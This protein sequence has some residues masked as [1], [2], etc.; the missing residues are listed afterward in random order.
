[1]LKG[2]I[3]ALTSNG[4]IR[5]WA[6][7]TEAPSTPLRVM[8][9]GS[10]GEVIAEGL[11]HHY[12]DD[13]VAAGCGIGWCEFRLRVETISRLRR[14]KLILVEALTKTPI[15][16]TLSIEYV[17]TPSNAITGIEALLLDDP[18]MARSIDQLK[19]CDSLFRDFILQRGVEA[20]VRATYV[21]VLGRPADF[22]GLRHYTRLIR[23]GDLKPF[24]LLAA[25][26][27]S[28]EF[29]SRPRLLGAPNSATFP[30]SCA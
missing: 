27:D 22:S 24:D 15:F 5:G 25:L 6:F 4:F 16:Q 9:V 12:R 26:A 3:D 14:I 10:A 30:L 23:S 8:I 2:H 19:G 7:D 28:P 20:F 17:E 21:Y 11:A 29:R 18:T 1:M 13:L